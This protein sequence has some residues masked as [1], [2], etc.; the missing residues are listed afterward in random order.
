MIKKAI[1]I[2]DDFFDTFV[3]GSL[4]KQFASKNR[5]GNFAFEGRLLF[6]SF[7][8]ATGSH[9]GGTSDVVDNLAVNVFCASKDC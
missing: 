5:F 4:S 8:V 2:K 6:D 7:F 9:N 1:P 3:H